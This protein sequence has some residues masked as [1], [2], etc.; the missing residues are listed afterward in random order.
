MQVNGAEAFKMAFEAETKARRCQVMLFGIIGCAITCFIA[1]V[2]LSYSRNVV[3]FT[4]AL[5]NDTA[6][7]DCDGEAPYDYNYLSGPF[8]DN[9]AALDYMQD[10]DDQC[11]SDDDYCFSCKWSVVYA[12]NGWLMILMAVNSFIIAA[13]HWNFHA[14][15]LTACCGCLLSCVNFAAVITTAVFRF[16][17]QG[18]LAALSEF[19]TKYESYNS[20]TGVV[21]FE[22]DRTYVTD[23]SWILALWIVQ[24]CIC[25]FDCCLR[26]AF[27]KP[28]SQEEIMKAAGG[29]VTLNTNEQLTHH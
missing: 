3:Q 21:M 18:K 10:L 27:S 17:T 6:S 2:Y 12:L 14:R 7:W 13:A 4:D 8:T 20:S 16:N 24:L 9:S 1:G 26:G 25:C 5:C 23:G 19:P 11:G 15:A 28:P 29:H 22:G